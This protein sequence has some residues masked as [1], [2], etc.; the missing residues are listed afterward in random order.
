MKT[1]MHA[2]LALYCGVSMGAVVIAGETASSPRHFEIRMRG[3]N[4]FDPKTIEIKVGDTITWINDDENEAHTATSDDGATFD[5]SE[6]ASFS[7][8]KR[9]K[10]T[11]AKTIAYHCDNHGPMTGKIV[12]AP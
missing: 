8:S 11:E 7:F 1:W 3:G 4:S 6:L 10:F 9:I 12:V 2:V 5:T